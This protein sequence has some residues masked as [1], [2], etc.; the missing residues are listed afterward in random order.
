MDGKKTQVVYHSVNG[1]R[2]G[3]EVAL[4]AKHIKS[5]LELGKVSDRVMCF[6]RETGER[7]CHASGVEVKK[8]S[9]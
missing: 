8:E 2:N 5:I 6:K 1:R 7:I 9:S 4:T 3:V